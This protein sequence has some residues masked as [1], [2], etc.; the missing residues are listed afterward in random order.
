M[1]MTGKEIVETQKKYYLQSWAKQKDVNPIPMEKAE[2][3]YLWDYDGNRYTDMSS[4]QVNVN[5][6]Y[7][8]EDINNAMK[9]QINKFAW[10]GPGYGVESRAKLA[11]MIVDL[12]PD[13]MGKIFFTNGGADANENAIKMARMYTGRYKVMLSLIHI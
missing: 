1:G 6:G 9:E 10:M 8:N 13:N 11:K 12:M 7:G 5:L 2:G 3:I 4:T